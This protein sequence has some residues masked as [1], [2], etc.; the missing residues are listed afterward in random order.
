MMHNPIQVLHEALGA[1]LYRDLP[2]VT[3]EVEDWK[4]LK[5]LS[6]E[7]QAEAYKNKTFP[8]IKR[9]ERPRPEEVEVYLFPQTWGSTA[10]GYGGV[11]GSAM[12]ADYTVVVV[13]YNDVCV[14]FGRDQ[15]AY[16]LNL[17]NCSQEGRHKFLEDLLSHSIASVTDKRRYS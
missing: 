3:Y 8:K 6:K 14:Y 5:A 17:L 16:K 11:G 15:L 9:T 4:A 2:D 13:L 7:E 1:A 12:T 10:L